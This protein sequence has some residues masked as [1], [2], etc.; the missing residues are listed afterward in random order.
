MAQL[1][2]P[3]Y[4]M[5]DPRESTRLTRK[6]NPEA[7]MKKYLEPYLFPGAEVLS[8]GC[9]PGNILR[10]ITLAYPK[11]IG[12][13]I[14]ISA[15]R[16]QQATEANHRT[17]ARPDARSIR[18]DRMAF[19]EVGNQNPAEIFSPVRIRLVLDAEP[20]QVRRPWLRRIKVIGVG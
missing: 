14:D 15:V 10:A 3:T 17:G 7:W 20:H 16:I 19:F 18:I 5:E 4:I 12:T 2:A 1:S 11:V 6:V 8:V 13:G 9:G